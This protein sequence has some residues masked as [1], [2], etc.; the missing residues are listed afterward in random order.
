[1][2]SFD[3]K[4]LVRIRNRF[5][6]KDVPAVV[7][8]VLEQKIPG[9]IHIGVPGNGGITYIDFLEKERVQGVTVEKS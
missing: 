3:K 7:K 4:A 9:E 6:G 5:A 8:E 1:M 2:V